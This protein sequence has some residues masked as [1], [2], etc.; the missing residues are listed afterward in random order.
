MY[1]LKWS[2][3]VL[4]FPF[5]AVFIPLHFRGKP[6]TC[7]STTSYFADEDVDYLN[8]VLAEAQNA[9]RHSQGL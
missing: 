9:L 6:C 4:V 5:G 7:Y 2:Y 8:A 1:L 3:E